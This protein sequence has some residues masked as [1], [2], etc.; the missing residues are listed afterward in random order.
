MKSVKVNS[1]SKVQVLLVCIF[2][3]WAS[4]E[5]GLQAQIPLIIDHS[6]VTNVHNYSADMVNR[7]GQLK[8]F[9]SH[10]SIGTG[11]SEG[12]WNLN[13]T[14]PTL[15][16]LTRFSCASNPPASVQPGQVCDL[17]RGNPGWPTKISWFSNYLDGGWVYP[18]VDI[19]MNKLGSVDPGADWAAYVSSLQGLELR[20][21]S[22]TFVYVTIPITT[23]TDSAN[24]QR[25]GFNT[26]L[27]TWVKANGKILYDIADIEAHDTNGVPYTF[28]NNAVVYQRLYPGFAATDGEHPAADYR[29]LNWLARG[30]YAVANAILTNRGP[31]T[32]IQFEPARSAI[33]LE[34]TSR[35]DEVYSVLHSASLDAGNWQVIA[36]N[37][38]ANPPWN[39]YTSTVSQTSGSFFKVRRD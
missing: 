31:Y 3:T 33:V 15:Y 30:F 4:A 38:V 36:T 14:Q 5:L 37:L 19:V 26:N 35:S 32:R 8:W 39:N 13:L 22:T 12:V 23:N 28:T 6:S 2:L 21:P 27:R 24:I 17:W 20:Y 11:M 18:T 9:F 16:K 29:V 34:W 1:F 10:A 25:N 7:I